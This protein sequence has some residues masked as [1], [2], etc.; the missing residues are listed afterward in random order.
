[1]NDQYTPHTHLA[2]VKKT[3]L[4]Y[5]MKHETK[6]IK[7]IAKFIEND[8]I[9]DN[10]VKRKYPHPISSVN[11]RLYYNFSTS[12]TKIEKKSILIN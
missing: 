5:V 4:N 10:K 1:M 3:T 7:I 9:F 12:L 6:K 11:N 8:Y 2:T